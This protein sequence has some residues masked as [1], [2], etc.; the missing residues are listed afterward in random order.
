MTLT[1]DREEFGFALDGVGDVDGDG[2]PD[3][4]VGTQTS[5]GGLTGQVFVFSSQPWADLGG[6]LA[7]TLGAPALS[8]TGT[9][10]P[11]SP[12]TLSLSGALPGAALALVVG[13]EPLV[14]PFKGGTLV[15]APS[16]ILT[17]LSVSGSGGLVVPTSWPAAPTLTPGSRILL[18]A[19]VVDAGGPVGYAAS[20]GISGTT[21]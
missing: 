2:L 1:G 6:A 15:P 13:F 17:G 18:P 4:A 10:H 5:L 9:L 16:L 8:A 3:L 7:G 19:W 21:P 11:G 14:A 20:N 12:L